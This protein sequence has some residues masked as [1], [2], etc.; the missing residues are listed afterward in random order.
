MPEWLSTAAW[1]VVTLWAIAIA[2]GLGML[3]LM[4]FAA[5]GAARGKG[6]R[7]LFWAVA[8]LLYGPVSLLAI[9]VLP[10]KR[11]DEA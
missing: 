7:S 6:R 3:A 9:H 8:T 5:I 2:W 10:P 4:V 11:R 1:I